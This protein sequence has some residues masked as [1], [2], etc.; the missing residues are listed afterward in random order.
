[1]IS[2]ALLIDLSGVLPALPSP[3]TQRVKLN[4][5]KNQ[6]QFVLVL[7]FLASQT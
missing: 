3:G 2:S 4:L 6:T 5:M 1:M 7:L